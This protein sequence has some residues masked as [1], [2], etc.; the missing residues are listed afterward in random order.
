MLETL[1]GIS[2][3]GVTAARRCKKN[4]S[5]VS[6]T[7]KSVGTTNLLFDEMDYLA[8]NIKIRDKNS[9]E[10]FNSFYAIS[11][12]LQWYRRPDFHSPKFINGHANAEIIGPMGLHI[13][14][15]IKVSITLMR[16]HL[17][18]PDHRHSPEEV[19][20]VLSDGF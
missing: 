8:S 19:Y 14:N 6:L 4:L 20:T 10:L 7:C 2:K 11:N 15:D 13:S 17:I 9:S 1:F 16:R 12:A 3:K 18:Y 5:Q